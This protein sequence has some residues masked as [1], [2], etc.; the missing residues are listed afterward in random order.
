MLESPHIL[1]KKGERRLELFDD[2]VLVRTFDIVLGFDP[3][4]HKQVEGDGRTPEGEFFICA[5]NPESKYHLSV[6]I[7][8]PSVPDAERGLKDGLITEEEHRY[9][10][11]AISAGKM[12]PQKTRLGGEIYIHGHTD[13]STTTAGCIRLTNEE[14]DFLYPRVET[15]T[16]VRIVK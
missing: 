12:P 8:Y 4:G 15:G 5:K 9:I 14:M 10:V 7:S 2:G 11:E 3:V 13:D 16:V 1:I 6:C